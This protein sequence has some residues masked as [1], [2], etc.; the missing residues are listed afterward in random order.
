MRPALPEIRVPQ[1]A[2]R[3]LRHQTFAILWTA[4]VVS[5]VGGWMYAAASAWL[6]TTLDGDPLMV[7][8]VQVATTLPMFLI[9]L[10]AGALSDIVDRRH[11]LIAAEV[12]ITVTSTTLALLIWLELITPARLLLLTFLIEAGAAATA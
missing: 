1:S 7:S 9:A 2:W 4:T 8:L 12:F 10:P 3:P 11:F 6:M 5:N